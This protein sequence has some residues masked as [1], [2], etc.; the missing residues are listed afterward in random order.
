MDDAEQDD[1]LTL[2]ATEFFNVV[3]NP[4]AGMLCTF[5]QMQVS[6]GILSKDEAKVVIISALDLINK[7]DYPQNVLAN[8]HNM[9][10][11]MINAIDKFD[12]PPHNPVS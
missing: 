5:L 10:L 3:V 6:K 2:V 11:R 12:P 4:L 1:T 7:T 9:L 8:G